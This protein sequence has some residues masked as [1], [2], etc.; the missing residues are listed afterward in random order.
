MNAKIIFVTAGE[1]AGKVGHVITKHTYPETGLEVLS[2]R[3]RTGSAWVPAK[4]VRAATPA[5]AAQFDDRLRPA[6]S[7]F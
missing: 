7:L 1:L 2:V 3:F 6:E 5:E 4:D